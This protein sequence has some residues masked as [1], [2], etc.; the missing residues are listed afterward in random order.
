MSF[1]RAVFFDHVRGKL[2]GGFPGDKGR[3][4]IAGLDA[5]IDEWEH[6]GGGDIRWLAYMLATAFVETAHSM[7]P[8]R[9][10]YYLAGKVHD[11]EAWRKAH[12]RYYPWY[13]RGYVQLTWRNNYLKADKELRLG[14]ALIQ[15]P[16]LALEPKIAADVM[17]EGMKGGWFTG[18][19]LSDYIAGTRSDYIGARRIINGSDR[20]VEIA[21]HAGAFEAAVRAGYAVSPASAPT[22]TTV[23]TPT[24]PETEKPKPSA[25]AEQKMA[26]TGAAAGAAVVAAAAVG[27]TEWW[28]WTGLAVFIIA[29][30]GVAFLIHKKRIAGNVA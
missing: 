26:A 7:Q 9:E 27:G 28:V 17:F 16:D 8:V 5:L 21:D 20:A 1:N 11:V 14:G 24:Q 29:G 15:S 4:Q 22:G 25:T 23:I 3:Q 6:R 10:A 2:F 30:L 13:G 18:K 12:L 19:K